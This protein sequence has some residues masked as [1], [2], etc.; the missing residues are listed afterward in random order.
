M[1]PPRP[2]YA[3]PDPAAP[4][5]ALAPVPPAP[6]PPAPVPPTPPT[7]VPV[8]PAPPTP[9]VPALGPAVPLL[10]P[11]A[12]DSLVPPVASVALLAP[13]AAGASSLV[14]APP[15]ATTTDSSRPEV[16]QPTIPL[17]MGP[18]LPRRSQ[19]RERPQTLEDTRCVFALGEEHVGFAAERPE[20]VVPVADDDG[21]PLPFEHA[22][23]V[24]RIP[25][26]DG[27]RWF[28]TPTL[29]QV[30]NSAAFRPVFRCD[31]E[32]V[33]QRKHGRGL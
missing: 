31:V 23:V 16:P 32:V 29:E 28:E 33:A 11:S 5:V 2:Q 12:P 3:P 13:P 10:P 27:A 6:V 25:G 22:E 1:Q 19:K 9:V 21:S 15:Q 14:D 26:S 24:A 7:P 20:R 17:A 30:S 18:R 4:S 8:P